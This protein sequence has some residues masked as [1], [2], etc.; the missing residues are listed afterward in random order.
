MW[1]TPR[2]GAWLCQGPSCHRPA[3]RGGFPQP[4]CRPPGAWLLGGG[5]KGLT[6]PPRAHKL[7]PNPTEVM[8]LGGGAFRGAPL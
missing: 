6:C 2:D 1:E 7:K 4:R 3:K 8:V 5:Y